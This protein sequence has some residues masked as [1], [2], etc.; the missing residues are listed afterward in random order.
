LNNCARFESNT[1]VTIWF[2]SK[3][4]IFAQH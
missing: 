1:E 4:R 2:D 3:F